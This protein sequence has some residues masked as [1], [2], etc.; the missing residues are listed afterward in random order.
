MTE[1]VAIRFGGE[2]ILDTRDAVRVLETSHPPVFYMPIVDFVAGAL[3]A[4]PGSSFCEYKGSARY[5]D[6]RGGGLVAAGAA[7]NYPRPNPGFEILAD[8]VA[9]YAGPM[10]ECTVGGEVV[11]PQPGGFYGGWVTSSIVG[12]F[13][14]SPG[15]QG[16]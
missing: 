9:V 8:R 2:T 7:W 16:W 1:R 3:T 4:A 15:T 12:P 5:L 13:K 10:D 6:V 14:G 11:V